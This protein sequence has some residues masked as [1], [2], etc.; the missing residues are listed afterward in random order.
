MVSIKNAFTVSKH[1]SRNI[2]DNIFH[3]CLSH[4]LQRSIKKQQHKGEH[5]NDAIN[6]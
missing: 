6:Y 1:Y 3:L 2:A 5:V 4:A